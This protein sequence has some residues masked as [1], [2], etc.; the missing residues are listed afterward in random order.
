MFQVL[1]KLNR[2]EFSKSVTIAVDDAEIY[3]TASFGSSYFNKLDITILRNFDFFGG[4]S[5]SHVRSAFRGDW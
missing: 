2:E 4:P 1:E 5:Q 3:Q